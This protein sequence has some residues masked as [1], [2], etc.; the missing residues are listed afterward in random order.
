MQTM[1]LLGGLGLGAGLMYL[2]DTEQGAERRDQVRGHLVD[3]GRQTG[4]RLDDTPVRSHA[5]P[6]GRGLNRGGAAASA[7]CD[8]HEKNQSA[9]HARQSIAQNALVSAWLAESPRAWR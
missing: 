5:H 9:P 3:Y 4:D 2:M 8:T 7:E 1:W 6:S